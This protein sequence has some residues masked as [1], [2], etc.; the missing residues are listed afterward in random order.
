MLRI[1]VQR[2]SE[3]VTIK[4]KGRFTGPSVVKLSHDWIELAGSKPL[5]IDLRSVTHADGRGV[6]TLREIQSL[7]GAKLI[8]NS[9][10]T[11]Y[12]AEGIAR[13]CTPRTV[14]KVA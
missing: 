6:K 5:L 13:R 11:K 12:V 14:K 7:T 9:P 3:T 4:L 8:T 10:L 2:D 1:D